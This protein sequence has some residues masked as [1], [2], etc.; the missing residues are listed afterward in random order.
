MIGHKL[1]NL[2]LS[3]RLGRII[4]ITKKSKT[5]KNETTINGYISNAIGM[6]LVIIVFGLSKVLRV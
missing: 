6:R 3:K 5:K 1:V 2:L 4:H